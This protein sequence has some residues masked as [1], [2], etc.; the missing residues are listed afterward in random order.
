MIETFD[1]TYGTLSAIG[2]PES[3]H[4]SSCVMKR[5]EGSP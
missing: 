2:A 3:V 1:L 4:L 5:K